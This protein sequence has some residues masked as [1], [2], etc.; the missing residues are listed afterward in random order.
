MA[1][2]RYNV[3]SEA[4]PADAA[5][6]IEAAIRVWAEKWAKFGDSRTLSERLFHCR[7]LHQLS[8]TYVFCAKVA[9]L[10]DAPDL[11]SGGETHGGSSPPFRTNHLQRIAFPDSL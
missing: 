9:E 6:K 11:G 4:D 2:D 1:I 5:Q 10:A 7:N 8:L 3:I